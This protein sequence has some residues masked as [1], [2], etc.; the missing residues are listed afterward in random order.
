MMP[1]DP[2]GKLASVEELISL[3]PRFPCV[4][5]TG[6]ERSG[7]TITTEIISAETGYANIEEESWDND[8]TA[9]W[10]LLR[11]RDRIVVHAPHLT[12]RV[13]EIGRH[14]PD[15]VLVVFMLRQVDDIVASQRR[16]DWG[17]RSEHC[18]DGGDPKG[19]GNPASRWYD[20]VS[21]DLFRDEIDPNAHLCLNRQVCWHRQQKQLVP[22]Y[23]E[24]AYET[25]RSHRLW[26]QPEHRRR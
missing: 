25:L 19:W 2:F 3:V 18:P 10:R 23:V 1:P 14:C 26:L 8:F 12:Y 4:A 7:T 21:Y 24:V 5:V 11:T 15:R 16:N 9:L 20:R 6:P 22:H 17:A 13:H